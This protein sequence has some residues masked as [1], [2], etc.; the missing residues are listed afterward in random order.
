[1]PTPPSAEESPDG[2]AAAEATRVAARAADDRHGRD[3]VALHVTELT[4][5]AD[6]FLLVSATSDTQ[7][8]AIYEAIDEAMSKIGREPL[9]VE[10]TGEFHWV[11]MDYADVVIHIFLETSRDFYGLERLWGD[12]P[13]LTLEWDGPTTP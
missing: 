10:G 5:L 1:M 11:L 7:V 6:Y 13:R 2:L 12:A 3:I 8:R 9:H 4:S